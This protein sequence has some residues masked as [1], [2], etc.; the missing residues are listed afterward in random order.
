MI[1]KEGH[2]IGELFCPWGICMSQTGNIFVASRN[3]N[4]GLQSF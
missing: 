2:G 4:F 1:G 3:N